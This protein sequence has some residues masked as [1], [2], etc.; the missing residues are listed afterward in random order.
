MNPIE[1]AQLAGKNY[2]L[3]T[4]IYFRT[5]EDLVKILGHYDLKD[6]NILTVL[7]SSDQLFSCFYYGAK[8]VDTF[9]RSYVTLYYYYLRKWLMLYKNRIYPSSKFFDGE[10]E[11]TYGLIQ[12]IKPT[13]IEEE[14]AKSFWLT[15]LK[16]CT[17]ET[18]DLLFE[19]KYCPKGTIPYKEDRQ[20]VISRLNEPVNFTLMDITKPAPI[21]KK[22]DVIIL[23][24]MLEYLNTREDLT[25]VRNNLEKLLDN[26][27]IAICT[28]KSTPNSYKKHK[29]EVKILTPYNLVLNDEHNDI[30]YSY[31]KR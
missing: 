18:N 27:G 29:T 13:T 8:K 14:N 15:Y 22:Y 26:N 17:K 9:D 23:S 25:A 3:K 28:N 4:L 16:T 24:N 19:G 10:V 30:S 2:D 7:A 31:K 12:R 21:N 11:N 5:N 6:K 1:L 20:K